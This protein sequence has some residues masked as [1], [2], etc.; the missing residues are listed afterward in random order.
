MS[1]AENPYGEGNSSKDILDAILSSY[2]A[3]ELKITV[4]EDIMKNRTRKLLQIKEHISV[5]EF[6]SN[7]DSIIKMVFENGN[8]RFPHDN[9]NLNGKIALIDSFKAD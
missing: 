7:R 5:H 1:E 4:P 2:N 3:G 8:A 9:L 6:E